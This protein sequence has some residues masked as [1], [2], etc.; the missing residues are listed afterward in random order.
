MHLFVFLSSTEVEHAS[1]VRWPRVEF[2]SELL[3]HILCP[4]YPWIV[5]GLNV[6]VLLKSGSLKFN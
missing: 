1:C 2:L 4:F 6:D 5:P 3:N